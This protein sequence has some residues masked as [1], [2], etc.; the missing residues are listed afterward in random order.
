MLH[1]M[2]ISSVAVIGLTGIA[3]AA[4]M[5][6]KAPPPVYVPT[7]T[8][9]YIGGHAG[10]GVG[11]SSSQYTPGID[12]LLQIGSPQLNQNFD[13]KGFFGGG[14]AGCQLQTGTFLWG[15]EGDWSSFSN[16]SSRNFFNREPLAKLQWCDEFST[17]MSGTRGVRGV[18][19]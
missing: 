8:G 10:Y 9:C 18:L 5:P 4:D 1:K 14:Q 2:L 3:G 13:N 16:S 19:G 17:G 11:T 15:L 6:I 12:A 7:W